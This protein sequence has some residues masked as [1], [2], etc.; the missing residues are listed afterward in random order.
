MKLGR[1]EGE[2]IGIG[3]LCRGVSMKEVSCT[4]V[5]RGGGRLGGGGLGGKV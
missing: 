2:G 5:G 3:S 1:W 4:C